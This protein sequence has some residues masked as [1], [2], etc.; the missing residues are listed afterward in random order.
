VIF[1]TRRARNGVQRRAELEVLLKLIAAAYTKESPQVRSVILFG[2]ITLGEFHPAFSDVDLAVVCEGDV[3]ARSCTKLPS[4]VHKAVTQCGFIPPAHVRPKQV[5]LS[6]LKKMR[7]LDW[8][9]WVSA[10][11]SSNVTDTPYPFT[12]CD[13]W[14]LHRLGRALVGE[15]LRDE[16]PFRSAKPIHPQ[17]ELAQLKWYASRLA[18][19]NPFAGLKGLDLMGEIIYYGTTFTRCL[20]TLRTGT[21]AGRVASTRWYARIFGGEAGQHARL[22]GEC[23]CR[24]D[25]AGLQRVANMDMLWN[26][27]TCY[28]REVLRYAMPE[29]IPPRQLPSREGFPAWLERWT[30]GQSTQ[31]PSPLSG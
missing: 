16:F 25:A 3:P 11:A 21:V 8:R 1:R 20:R 10:T 12:L 13:T 24:T 17:V 6:V 27:F 4:A 28:A 9:V 29:V 2:G 26:L 5:S 7:F 31:G 15:D 22:L 14:L 23:R 19:G 18:M 30:T